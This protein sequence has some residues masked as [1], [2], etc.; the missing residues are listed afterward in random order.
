MK[1]NNIAA[2]NEIEMIEIYNLIK[3]YA[4]QNDTKKLPD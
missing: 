2:E 3:N 1:L 4:N